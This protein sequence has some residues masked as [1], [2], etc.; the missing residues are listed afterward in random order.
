MNSGRFWPFLVSSGL[1]TRGDRFFGPVSPPVHLSRGRRTQIGPIGGRLWVLAP[2]PLKVDH[3]QPLKVDHHGG[4]CRI[5]STFKGGCVLLPLPPP[6]LAKHG[7]QHLRADYKLVP[8]ARR[9]ENVGKLAFLGGSRPQT[10]RATRLR[11]QYGTQN[12]GAEGR[13]APVGTGGA[14]SGGSGGGSP[15]GR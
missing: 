14:R 13:P 9:R 11:R 10:P 4:P 12:G 5:R 7:V 1:G 6:S 2:P 15:P 3:H 8:L